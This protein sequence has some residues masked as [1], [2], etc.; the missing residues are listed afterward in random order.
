MSGRPD[1]TTQTLESSFLWLLPEG[2]SGLDVRCSL[3]ERGATRQGWRVACRTRAQS[4]PDRQQEKGPQSCTQALNSVTDLGEP[5]GPSHAAQAFK[6]N[7]AING[8]L[9]PFAYF[10]GGKIH[11]T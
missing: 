1:L 10:Y 9:S 8:G 3:G 5:G 4:L 11:V 2:K 6:V 7:G